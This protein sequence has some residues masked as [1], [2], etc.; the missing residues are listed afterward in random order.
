MKVQRMVRAQ[1]LDAQMELMAGKHVG[2]LEGHQGDEGI[3]QVLVY[4]AAQLI[5]F[6]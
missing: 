1:A 3:L 2:R 6:L 5:M 4:M